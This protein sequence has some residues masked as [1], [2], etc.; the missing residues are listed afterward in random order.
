MVLLLRAGAASPSPAPA[1]I[2]CLLMLML[3]WPCCCHRSYPVALRAN[4]AAVAPVSPPGAS[5]HGLAVETS[6][7]VSKALMDLNALGPIALTRAAVP[8][9]IARYAGMSHLMYT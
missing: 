9:L 6:A 4:P 8:K 1:A 5:Q 2:A 7:E 3:C